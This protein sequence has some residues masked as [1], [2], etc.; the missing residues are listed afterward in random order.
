MGA[1]GQR[2]RAEVW[3]RYD[4]VFASPSLRPTD[5]RYRDDWRVAGLSDHAAIVVTFDPDDARLTATS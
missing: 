2:E 4:H 3:R 5:A 1:A